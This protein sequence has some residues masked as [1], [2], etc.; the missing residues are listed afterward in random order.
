MFWKHKE[1]V[2]KYKDK[3]EK[4]KN[5]GKKQGQNKNTLWQRVKNMLLV[6]S[7]YTDIAPSNNLAKGKRPIWIFFFNKIKFN[8]KCYKLG[9]EKQK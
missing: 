4:Y 3:A 7:S 1:R 2:R 9:A 8:I 6:C 5:K